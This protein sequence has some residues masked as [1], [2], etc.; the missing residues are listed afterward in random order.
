MT[1]G[2]KAKSNGLVRARR[3]HRYTAIVA[4]LFTLMWSFSGGYHALTKL[5][6]ETEPV[7]QAINFSAA[8]AGF[9]YARLRA[10]AGR[11]MANISLVK[12][13]DQLYWRTLLFTEH[14]STHK[15]LMKDGKATLPP[16]L[17]IH[18]GD[19][20]VMPE[21]D[22]RYA[23][24]LAAQF[25][26]QAFSGA[27]L[28]GQAVSGAQFRGRGEGTDLAMSAALSVSPVTVFDDEY[29][30]TDKRLPVWRVSYPGAG[31]PRY[32]VETSS[33]Q[34]AAFVND[35]VW[36]EGYSFSV[37]HKHHFMDWGGKTVRDGSTM[38]WAAIQVLMAIIGLTLYVRYR[39]SR[40]RPDRNRPD[41]NQP[42][43]AGLTAR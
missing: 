27:Q 43:R 22:Q 28:S 31:H 32:Y 5:T 7:R 25:R 30:F 42:D 38:F 15:D 4:A 21:G 12:I 20:S 19:Y 17:Y 35:A 29:N 24:S 14:A 36:R 41:R 33:G 10:A 18:A 26:G 9:D 8:D 6:A 40:N 13:N 2:A 1:R 34:L 39:I 37:F 11:Q 3:Y 16:V 23:V